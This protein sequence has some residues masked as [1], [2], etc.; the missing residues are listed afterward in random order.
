MRHLSICLLI[1]WAALSLN[2]CNKDDDG[3]TPTPNIGNIGITSPHNGD[4]VSG[5]VIVNAMAE[6]E[7]A[8][9]FMKLIIDGHTASA[10]I[11]SFPPYSFE[12]NTQSLS[13]GSS[14]TLQVMAFSGLNQ[15]VSGNPI[16]VI[17]GEYIPFPTNGL[18]LAYELNSGTTIRDTLGSGPNGINH[19][20][21]FA[22]AGKIGGA[23][24]LDGT[25]DYI[26]IPDYDAFTIASQNN[27][28]LFSISVWV[29]LDALTGD[30]P[31]ISKAQTINPIDDSEWLLY[32]KS[33]GSVNFNMIDKQSGSK[34]ITYTNTSEIAPGQWN[35]IIVSF[36]GTSW[37]TPT[38]IYVNGADATSFSGFQGVPPFSY[39]YNGLDDVE[40]GCQ[41][42]L[43][44]GSA[45]YLKGAIDQVLLYNRKMTSEDI[46]RLYNSGKGLAYSEN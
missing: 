4:T 28:H 15:P 25:T 8:V 34:Q 31:V 42:R 38:H 45:T 10:L 6:N 16:S 32:I 18:L 33:D 5:K 12:W 36:E 17:I 37:A 2:S 29:K 21:S 43:S 14:H 19:G 23:F 40:I 27:T 39:T 35:H 30:Q 11:D 46:S 24:V 3:I 20:A 44:S 1:V 26:S 7:L 9:G 13:V 22:T 41:Y